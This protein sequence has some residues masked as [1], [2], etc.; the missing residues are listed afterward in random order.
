MRKEVNTSKG[1]V[2]TSLFP[3]KINN[4]IVSNMYDNSCSRRVFGNYIIDLFF[5]FG[6]ILIFFN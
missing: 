2:C 6:N 3:L 1:P 5:F 4:F